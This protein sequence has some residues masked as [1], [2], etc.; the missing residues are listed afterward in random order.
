M[1][2]PQTPPRFII[3]CSYANDSVALIQWAYEQ[4]LKD[5][6]VVYS[7]TK[8][9]APWWRNR[10]EWLE[11]WVYSLGFYTD[12]T[13][14]LGFVELARNKKAFPTQQFQWCSYIL[15]I[16]PGSRWLSENDPD[17][18]AVC[19]VGV[20]REESQD[21]ADFPRVLLSSTNHGG[22]VMVAPFADF[23][24]AERDALLTRAGLTPLPHRSMECSP[25]INSN[26]QDLQ[27]LTP[28]VIDGVAAVEEM[29]T[30]DFGLTKNGKPRT[31]FRPHRH[32]GA[33]GIREVVKWAHSPRG[34]YQPP[35]GIVIDS[36]VGEDLPPEQD[37]FN[38]RNN[39][40]CSN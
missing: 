3:F 13:D 17:A 9:S 27:A 2:R 31:L 30:R 12:R 33:V 26:R 23:S 4:G 14:S 19:L 16:E 18:R 15:K 38:T 8:W 20:R 11:F 34:K 1:G 40:Y 21:R 39:G 37:A 29:M 5:V 32:M 10:V 25:C 24:E 28:D 22:R 6:V 36:D 7:D 35:E